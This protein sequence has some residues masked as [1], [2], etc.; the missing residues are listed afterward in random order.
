[1]VTFSSKA[2]SCTLLSL[3][4]IG[5]G[6][7]PASWA[8]KGAFAELSTLH[9]YDVQLTGSLPPAWAEKGCLPSLIIFDFNNS[10]LSGTLPGSWG[11]VFKRLSILSIAF[12][13]L[14]GNRLS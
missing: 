2:F 11:H 7:L 4:M 3:L 1:M 5:I 13:K 9:I 14:T 8:A 10:Q 6:T 12:S